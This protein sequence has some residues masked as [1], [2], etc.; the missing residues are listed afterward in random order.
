MVQIN[1]E[2]APTPDAAAAE[3]AALA[4]HLRT[5]AASCALPLPL[6][7]LLLQHHSGLGNAAQPDAPVYAMDSGAL[8]A[9]GGGLGVG[10][11]AAE[12]PQEGGNR[13]FVY[14]ALC[15]LTFRVS[16]GA[17]FQVGCCGSCFLL[18]VLMFDCVRL[19]AHCF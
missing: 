18:P 1:P 9:T 19:R 5:R 15:E 13:A 6:T 17:F 8:L 7:C 11:A 3:C 10:D 12:A 2:G 14:D 16:S 4:A